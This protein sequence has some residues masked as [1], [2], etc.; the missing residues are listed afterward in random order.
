MSEEAKEPTIDELKAEVSKWKHHFME[1]YI[2]NLK[3]Q[4]F[5]EQLYTKIAKCDNAVLHTEITRILV[6]MEVPNGATFLSELKAELT[7]SSDAKK[8]T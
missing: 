1:Q 6:E 8:E 7:G 2:S 3:A 5:F 4:D